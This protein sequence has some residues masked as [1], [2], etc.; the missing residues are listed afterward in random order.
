MTLRGAD[1]VDVR[2]GMEEY[3]PFEDARAIVRAHDLKTQK[4]WLAWRRDSR[5]GNIPRCP[6]VVY[7]GWCCL[8][9]WLK[10]E[11]CA[12]QVRESCTRRLRA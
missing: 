3:L 9:D 5:P 10:H 12:H 2:D 4:G 8:A 7:K 6:E 1:L 11:P